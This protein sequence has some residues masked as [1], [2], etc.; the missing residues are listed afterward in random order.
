MGSG[1][2]FSRDDVYY[3]GDSEDGMYDDGPLTPV[4]Q[5]V[6]PWDTL[7]E[8]GATSND[9][10]NPRDNLD[11]E[12]AK[13]R[14]GMANGMAYWYKR[15]PEAIGDIMYT[16]AEHDVE[17]YQNNPNAI[18][19][20][21][22]GYLREVRTRA[23]E[24]E[25]ENE[26]LIEHD[27]A[28][29]RA[30]RI[31]R[32]EYVESL[33]SD[34]NQPNNQPEKSSRAQQAADDMEQTLEDDYADWYSQQPVPKPASRPAPQPPEPASPEPAPEPTPDRAS[35]AESFDDI[36]QA[37]DNAN[38]DKEID[39]D[40]KKILDAELAHYLDLQSA[41]DQDLAAARAGDLAAARQQDAD[42]V[43]QQEMQEQQ[44][45]QRQQEA[46]MQQYATLL[47]ISAEDLQGLDNE[48]IKKLAQTQLV[49]TAETTNAN[50]Q[51][52]NNL[53]KG[54]SPDAAQKKTGEGGAET[55]TGNGTE[56]GAE[57]GG[58][59]DNKSSNQNGNGE[60]SGDQP[61]D[62]RL[63]RI[64][65]LDNKL[66]RLVNGFE[67][68][69]TG[70]MVPG[71]A[72]LYARNR[73]LIVR[74]R[75]RAEFERRLQSY[76]QCLNEFLG[77]RA[78][79]SYEDALD[80]VNQTYA[81][82][83]KD[84]KRN[85]EERFKAFVDNGE[86]T[87][88]ELKAEWQRLTSKSNYLLGEIRKKQNRDVKRDVNS[89]LVEDLVE[90]REALKSA[91][92]EALKHGTNCRRVLNILSSKG[93]KIGLGVAAG[94]SVAATAIGVATGQL[95]PE[96]GY[97]A[98][99]A[100]L[101]AAKGAL[102]GVIMSRQNA[103]SSAVNSFAREG[104]EDTA[105]IEAG[106]KRNL[107]ISRIPELPEADKRNANVNVAN[108]SSWFTKRYQAA[109]TADRRSN[110]KRTAIAAGLSTA[111]GV[112]ASGLHFTKTTLGEPKMEVRGYTTQGETYTRP[113]HDHYQPNLD[114]VNVP[115][116]AGLREVYNQLGGDP[117]KFEEAYRIATGLDPKYGLVP[118]SNGVTAGT[119][120][121]V[122][123]FAHTYPGAIDTWPDTAR[124]YITD[125]A[126]E[127]AN[128]GLIDN[129]TSITR[130]DT[131]TYTYQVPN[132]ESVPG[133]PII[134]TNPTLDALA[135]HVDPSLTGG[136]AAAA[137]ASPQ[138]RA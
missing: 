91:T 126:N 118:G 46:L 39:T 128:H 25:S 112:F 109:N 68:P 89:G 119:N 111:I 59:K 42:Q 116:G 21:S 76:E 88:E 29:A 16:G 51:Q 13:K 80:A 5:D 1:E 14:Y 101:G 55:S 60:T 54:L 123:N 124:N 38:K 62:E 102:S 28:V 81:R 7:S 9:E 57:A 58:A 4:R 120:G 35:S 131:Y 73:R 67:D 52:L 8:T 15:H 107:K 11:L 71:L 108:V 19:R 86:H 20:L 103:K 33:H 3:N 129:V 64:R 83:V 36:W 104:E 132:L 114:Q 93:F 82:A 137:I 94:A 121:A 41:R 32:D 65:A 135:Q 97:T 24:I 127:W 90:Q 79:M 10:S 72:E 105:E 75:N 113:V 27:A 17:W 61:E 110:I 6:N 43:R 106:V 138:N 40:K 136:A 84:A 31:L 49:G 70:K 47:G 92:V 100:I 69:R 98:G 87:E 50:Y 96:L 56:V 134:T 44:E 78:E 37:L 77:L 22:D 48:Q 34:G 125:V 130:P 99:G 133:D 85:R 30:K 45:A 115:E 63:G 74:G 18:G 122:G 66:R 12:E 117:N 2:T 53:L 95:E 26:G 23:T